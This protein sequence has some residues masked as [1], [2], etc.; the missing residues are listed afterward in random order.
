MMTHQEEHY[1]HFVSSIEN[2]NNAWRILQEIK[3]CK[4]NPLVSAAF[5][6]ALIEYA[7]PYKDSFGVALNGKGKPIK[8]KLDNT[9]IPDKY[10]DL[11]KRVLDA[12]DQIYAHADLTVKEAKVYIANTSCGVHAS[13]VQNVIR[14]TEELSNIDV[15]IDLIEQTL[16]KM[17]VEVKLLEAKLTPSS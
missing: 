6:F 15:I 2:L 3:Q 12:R 4:G 7:K 13:I 10:L 16:E 5:Q 17:Y 8:Y 9:H 14:G 11:H 1:V